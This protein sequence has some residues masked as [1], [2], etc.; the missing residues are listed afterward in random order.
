MGWRRGS[1]RPASAAGRR[2]GATPSQDSRRAVPSACAARASRVHP[3]AVF[4]GR[5]APLQSP[6]RDRRRSRR[7]TVNS[8]PGRNSVSS[9]PGSGCG[10]VNRLFDQLH[11]PRPVVGEAPA[12]L[13]AANWTVVDPARWAM[14]RCRAGSM[15]RSWA[16]TTH[17]D[18]SACQ[19]ACPDG[20][21]KR[22]RLVGRCWAA[23][24]AGPPIHDDA[25]GQTVRDLLPSTKDLLLVVWFTGTLDQASS[26]YAAG[27][28]KSISSWL[29]RSASS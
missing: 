25:L 19:A 11:E 24:H 27:A 2:C 7:P 20:L 6:G 4:G 3:R 26:A 21:P 13:A 15:A 28:K 23:E 12:W 5:E 16:E 18:G 17:H 9:R 1:R 29:T 8:G 22:A 14:N 10:R